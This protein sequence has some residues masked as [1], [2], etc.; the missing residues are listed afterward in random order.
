MGEINQS[1][2]GKR[3]EN[4][5]HH[6]VGYLRENLNLTSRTEQLFLNKFF[7][8]N[9]LGFSQVVWSVGVSFLFQKKWTRFDPLFAS[10][11]FQTIKNQTKVSFIHSLKFRQMHQHSIQLLAYFAI[12]KSDQSEMMLL[13]ILKKWHF[14]IRQFSTHCLCLFHFSSHLYILHSTDKVN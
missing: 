8:H 6:S 9:R 3:Q 13:Y 1:R 7:L 2:N 12:M 14:K 5:F 11:D 10:M 4:E